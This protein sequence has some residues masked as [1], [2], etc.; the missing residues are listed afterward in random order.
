MKKALLVWGG[1]DGHEPREC[2]ERFVPFL[3]DKEFEIDVRDTLSVFADK[4]EMTDYDLI[5][6]CWTMGELSGDQESGLLEAVRAGAG[7]AGWHGGMGDAFRANTGY[8][9]MVGGQFVEH[10]GGIIEYTV[11]VTRP[12]DPIMDG[13]NDFQMRSE[14]Y[15]M[16]VDPSNEVL[17]ATTLTGDHCPWVEGCVMP[18]MWKRS[19]GEGRVFYSSLGH[20]A[21]DFD[22]RECFETMKRGMLW[23]CR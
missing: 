4:T 10:P 6:P 12:N 2:V 20:V 21:G 19:Y 18:V 7:V 9:F 3:R 14:C 16:H 15:Y 1:W 5:V 8:Q 11:N 22:V 13:I 17:A 23:A